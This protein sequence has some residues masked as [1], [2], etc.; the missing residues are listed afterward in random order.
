M[1]SGRS[2]ERASVVGQAPTEDDIAHLEQLG[3]RVVRREAGRH[4]LEGVVGVH[5]IED[6]GEARVLDRAVDRLGLVDDLASPRRDTLP[7]RHVHAAADEHLA[8]LEVE[9]AA[10]RV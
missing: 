8:G 4:T 3:V 2:G 6:R 10:V 1:T 7:V 5:V 9:V